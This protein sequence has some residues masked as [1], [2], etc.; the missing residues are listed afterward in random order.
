M[1]HTIPEHFGTPDPGD[2][3]LPI[4]TPTLTASPA[5]AP[6][7]SAHPVAAAPRRRRWVTW[8]VASATTLVVLGAGALSA[9]LWVVADHANA[10]STWYQGQLTSTHKTLA[11]REKSLADAKGQLSTAQ[12]QLRSVANEKAKAEDVIA[13][14]KQADRLFVAANEATTKCA[15]QLVEISNLPDSATRAQFDSLS[16]QLET[17]CDQANTA[18]DAVDAFLREHS[19]G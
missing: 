9:Y 11:D 3:T 10:R 15:D 2:P 5:N 7:Q 8:V 6:L 19:D 12:S 4:A 17:L 16:A 1:T 13:G 14:Q 18:N